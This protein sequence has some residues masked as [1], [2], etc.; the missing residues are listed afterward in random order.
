MNK[1]PKSRPRNIIPQ[2]S[3]KLSKRDAE[4]IGSGIN[5]P[6]VQ[7]NSNN[8]SSGFNSLNNIKSFNCGQG[9]TS[10]NNSG[11]AFG[12]DISNQIKNNASSTVS[13]EKI[14]N[15]NSNS[16]SIN[17]SNLNSGNHPKKSLSNINEKVSKKNNFLCCVML[18]FYYSIMFM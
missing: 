6:Q 14:S 11:R 1:I 9:R 18:F 17:Y 12:V 3:V 4:N 5:I 13:M 8:I 15:Q 7:I 10:K 16:N 2:Q